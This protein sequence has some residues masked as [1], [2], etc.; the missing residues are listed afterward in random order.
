MNNLENNVQNRNMP[1][2]MCNG[3]GRTKLDP[4][5][6]SACGRDFIQREKNN[7]NEEL[8]RY[9]NNFEYAKQWSAEYILNMLKSRG[10]ICTNYQENKIRVLDNLLSQIGEKNLGNDQLIISM[11]SVIYEVIVY[12]AYKLLM[13]AYK[14]DFKVTDCIYNIKLTPKDLDNNIILTDQIVC[15]EYSTG[16][17]I[18]L[19]T[20]FEILTI[21][22][23]KGLLT[24]AITNQQY[25]LFHNKG[26]YS[27]AQSKE[28]QLSPFSLATYI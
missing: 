11:D 7:T 24:F 10:L 6:C 22:K 18:Y 28:F 13:L 2:K 26:V 16:N 8:F 14:E 4:Y 20:L 15:I 9:I 12:W 25:S 1:C 17:S 23:R 27:V 5:H 21:R 3:T 19:D